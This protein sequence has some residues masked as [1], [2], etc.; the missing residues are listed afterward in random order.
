MKS[1]CNYAV[2]LCVYT[3]TCDVC[4]LAT[5]T[6]LVTDPLCMFMTNVHQ[7]GLL[8]GCGMYLKAPNKPLQIVTGNI[9]N[10]PYFDNLPWLRGHSS[11]T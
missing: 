8:D 1:T 5:R 10:V 4:S 3:C 11:V 9:Q 6:H 2:Q 7:L